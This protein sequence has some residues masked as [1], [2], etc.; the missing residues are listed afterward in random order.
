MSEQMF[1]IL[2][3]LEYFVLNKHLLHKAE[4]FSLLLPIFYSKVDLCSEVCC[5]WLIFQTKVTNGFEQKNLVF[6]LTTEG[7]GSPESRSVCDCSMVPQRK[8]LPFWL[9]IN[10]LKLRSHQKGDLRQQRRH[11]LPIKCQ[12]IFHRIKTFHCSVELGM[13]CLFSPV[14]VEYLVFQIIQVSHFHGWKGV[15]PHLSQLSQHLIVHRMG[16]WLK[17]TKEAFFCKLL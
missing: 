11:L 2:L 5:R 15:T 14:N 9:A 16:A 17:E 4:N 6:R 7:L 1:S 10:S 8:T 3:Q 13:A 12:S